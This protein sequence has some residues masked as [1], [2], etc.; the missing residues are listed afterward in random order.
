M[1]NSSDTPDSKPTNTLSILDRILQFRYA[2]IVASVVLAID[3]V[4][5]PLHVL[6]FPEV[7]W[8]AQQS[9]VPIGLMIALTTSYV[10]FMAA[11]SPALQT[12]VEFLLLSVRGTSIFSQIFSDGREDI[13][14]ESR[15]ANGFVK[16]LDARK[17]AL[18]QKDDFWIKRVS[19]HL[20]RQQ[21]NDRDG[22]FLG[23]VSFACIL[24]VYLDW[25]LGGASSWLHAAMY[26]LMDQGGVLGIATTSFA[27][28]I[29]ALVVLPWFFEFQ[30][31]YHT[32]SYNGWIEHPELAAQYLKKL[33]EKRSQLRF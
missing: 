26:W 3:V 8:F 17:T 25:Q 28:L 24:L 2:L 23:N 21:T 20:E 1:N 31:K 11:L 15:Y 29:L 16:V 30:S 18:E 4:R 9:S 19:E 27:L 13:S 7:N 6:G 32:G 14:Y 5:L 22:S 10:F 12:V 33:M